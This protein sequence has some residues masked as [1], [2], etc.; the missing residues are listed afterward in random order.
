[1]VKSKK[2][3]YLIIAS[4]LLVILLGTTTYA[5]FNYTRTGTANV[6]RT[7][8]IAFNSTQGTAITLTDLFPIDVSQ[9]IPDDNTK[10]GTL[11]V[12]VTG[13]TEYTGGIEYLV[14]AV[15]VQNTVGSKNLPISIDV[16]VASNTEN[17]PAT[18]LGTADDDYFT[19]RGSTTSY[20]KV[21]ATDVIENDEQL[22]VGYI[23]PEQT[24]VDGNIIIKAYIDAERI[25]I[26]DTYYGNATVTP[27]PTASNDMYGT[28]TEWVDGRVVLTTTEWNSLQTNGISFQIKVEAQED[29]WVEDPNTLF[30]AVKAMSIGTMNAGTDFGVIASNDTTNHPYGVYQLIESNLTNPIYFFRGDHTVKNNVIFDNKCWLVVRTTET[31]STRMIYNGTPVDGKCTTI[32]G[33]STMISLY[34]SDNVNSDG[35]YEYSYTSK[36]GF[37]SLKSGAQFKYNVN[38]NDAKYVGYTYDNGVSSNM[39]NALEAWYEGAISNEEKK[40]IETSIY[41]N[42]T[43]VDESEISYTKFMSETRGSA[44]TPSIVCPTGA[45]EISSKVGFLTVDEEI[46]AGRTWN[47]GMQDYLYNNS[48]WWLGSPNRFYWS[49][50]SMFFVSTY[51]KASDNA[52]VQN[53]NGLRPVVSILSNTEITGGDGSQGSPWI[54]S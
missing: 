8:R 17:S 18:T 53:N 6:I 4:F 2:Q 40:K 12:N 15:N 41:C 14:T 31:N 36:E 42:D 39:K 10:V 24:G 27:T 26:S 16:S 20:Y 44:N 54:I 34:Q 37:T 3:M 21:L 30:Y 9:G 11:T 23:A 38:Y 5:F 25:A 48:Y 45:N 52:N 49:T 13:D 47:S 33:N 22:V 7:G 35:N 43:R 51:S 1:M 50:A 29:T 46:L 32:E 19:D 28:T